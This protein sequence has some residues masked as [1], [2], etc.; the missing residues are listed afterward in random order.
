M[1]CQPVA[2]AVPSPE[3]LKSD[4][5]FRFQRVSSEQRSA[6]NLQ[7]VST[8]F[9]M[10]LER[11]D[12]YFACTTQVQYIGHWG[13]WQDVVQEEFNGHFSQGGHSSTAQSSAGWGQST[14]AR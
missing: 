7:V 5:S 2:R 8:R 14:R 6:K 3:K 10:R 9:P 13:E 11:K 1:N 4:A 12:K